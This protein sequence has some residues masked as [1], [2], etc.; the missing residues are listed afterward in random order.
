MRAGR[1][2]WTAAAGLLLVTVLAF[3]PSAVAQV[4][5]ADMAVTV[6]TQSGGSIIAGGTTNLNVVF[7]NRGPGRATNARV[8][9]TW[10]QSV[11]VTVTSTN[12]RANCSTGGGLTCTVGALNA[13]QRVTVQARV[14]L[15]PAATGNMIATARARS[16][17]NDPNGG[18]DQR[19][20]NL[21]IRTVADLALSQSI[22]P[23]PPQQGGNATVRPSVTNRGPS[24]A[25]DV[26]ITISIPGGV[27]LVGASGNCGGGGRTLVCGVGTL[28][29]GAS[30]AVQV[31]YGLGGVPAGSRLTAAASAR[32]STSESN[33]GNNSVAQSFTVGASTADVSI[34]K[35]ASPNPAGVGST[36]RF[37]VTVSNA[38]P[39]AA[40][41]V[42]V[43]D[44]LPI[45][46]SLRSAQAPGGCSP[47]GR[48]IVC[49]VGTLNPGAG[50]SVSIVVEV[51]SSARPGPVV[52]R[53]TVSTDT[54]DRNQNNNAA[55][56]SLGI[57]TR[58]TP[59]TTRPLRPTSTTRP[60]VVPTEVAG[61]TTTLIGT[62][63]GTGGR[64]GPL[65]V[66]SLLLAAGVLLW[67]VSYRLRGAAD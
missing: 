44:T 19:Q 31:T 41:G 28:A 53:V 58:P 17:Q 22:Q 50:A 42:V 23:N 2:R 16:N 27:T 3:A 59:P 13:G 6:L 12:P 61:S 38:G 7:V 45:G 64:G 39:S 43:T 34:R 46:L 5:T 66:A 62:L 37:A 36:V 60:T 8:I 56:I 63:P 11:S 49:N 40:R 67:A 4:Q 9:I 29:P 1:V 54:A 51:L 26:V 65:A 55:T 33:G 57:T 47:L 20:S 24:N 52:N 18:N 15:S 10:N 32:S 25:R 21:P 14:R 48:T 30:A 35:L